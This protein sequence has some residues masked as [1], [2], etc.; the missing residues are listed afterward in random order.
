MRITRK[1]R[2]ARERKR[3]LLEAKDKIVNTLRKSA[4]VAVL[5]IGL[6]SNVL[7]AM[8][9]GAQI[10]A[11]AGSVVQ[12][13]NAMT[14]NQSSNKMSIN[15]DSFSI[16]AHE[17]VNFIQPT[18]RSVVLNRV[19]GSDPSTIYG[20]LSANGKVF[21]INPSGVLFAPGSQ[22]DVG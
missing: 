6:N 8:P 19:I 20:Q 22:V 1:Q 4:M 5:A 17:K 12:N 16:A 15:W 10:T 3:R 7:W 14:V 18:S 11:G 13:N 2:R 9:Q 21:L